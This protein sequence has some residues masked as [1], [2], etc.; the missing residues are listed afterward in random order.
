[1]KTIKL[2]AALCACL[3]TAAVHAEDTVVTITIDNLGNT[4]AASRQVRDVSTYGSTAGSLYGGG[5][6]D[7][8]S[9]TTDVFNWT[10]SGTGTRYIY[11][12]FYSSASGVVEQWAEYDSDATTASVYFETWAGLTENPSGPSDFYYDRCVK[13]E[14]SFNVRYTASGSCMNPESSLVGPGDSMCV[15][16]VNNGGP[17]TITWTAKPVF[18]DVNG[19]EINTDDL[20]WT[21]TTDTGGGD[22]WNEGS[23]PPPTGGVY[24]DFGPNGVSADPE[25]NIDWNAPSTDLAKDDTLKDVGEVLHLDIDDLRRSNAANIQNAVAELGSLGV[26]LDTVAAN[27]ASGSG[28]VTALN[29]IAGLI[30]IGNG[31]LGSIA[32][33]TEL[34]ASH[35]GSANTHLLNIYN[36]IL[37][38]N[39]LSQDQITELQSL[40]LTNTQTADGVNLMVPDI[41]AIRSTIE[42]LE[43]LTTQIKDTNTD[44]EADTTN[45]AIEA[46]EQNDN[47]A[48]ID[49]NTDEIEPK[50]DDIKTAIDEQPDYT[51]VLDSIDTNTGE[52]AG[53]L[54]QVKDVLD[55]ILSALTPDSLE[56]PDYAAM[57]TA[58]NAE[59]EGMAA[60]WEAIA[61]S[62]PEVEI[63]PFS[64][65]EYLTVSLPNPLGGAPLSINLDPRTSAYEPV[66]SFVRS[67]E[68]WAINLWIVVACFRALVP[69]IRAAPQVNQITTAN[70]QIAGTNINWLVALAMSSIIIVTLGAIPYLFVERFGL[71]PFSTLG[72]NPLEGPTNAVSACLYII[73]A[74]FPIA[75]AVSAVLTVHA[76]EFAIPKVWWVKTAVVRFMAG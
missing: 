5:Q 44:I 61:E 25:G 71:N 30:A 55:G 75:L 60:E 73:D 2:I 57:E 3:G 59:T 29:S 42:V 16:L 34:A 67:F 40:G 41:D 58:A 65:G 52:S 8:V 28:Q 51:D 19:N 15:Q 46:A 10:R 12:K 20:E 6:F 14:N 43:T 17:C 21:V 18:Y 9:G 64:P 45:I 68:V 23:I 48:A 50:L 70:Q 11:V 36:S 37:A 53:W 56:E 74:F 1:M 22:R 69:Y 63:P 66:L 27:T 39:A 7:G 32:T 54:G 33:N 76:F 31:T 49:A 35:A 38:G 26:K 24:F 47:L 13:N 4:V 62:V 72:A